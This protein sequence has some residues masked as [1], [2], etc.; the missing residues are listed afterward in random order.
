MKQVCPSDH[1]EYEVVEGLNAV[2]ITA[3]VFSVLG[4]LDAL[5]LWAYAYTGSGPLPSLPSL[6]SLPF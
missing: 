4:A 1:P 6:P 5:G 2:E 3:I